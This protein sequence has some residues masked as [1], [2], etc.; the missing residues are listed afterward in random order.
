MKTQSDSDFNL[1][2]LDSLE[3]LDLGRSLDFLR[4][5]ESLPSA[6]AESGRIKIYM[7]KIKKRIYN[8]VIN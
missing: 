8:L 1:P 2:A 5:L 3:S 7:Q 6:P 4:H